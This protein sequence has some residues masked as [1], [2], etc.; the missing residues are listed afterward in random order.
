M[1]E[2]RTITSFGLASV[3]RLS[4]PAIFGG[5]FFA[6]GI[7]LILSLFGLAI[8][9]A[10]AGPEGATR[11]V[12]TWSGIWSLVTVFFGF[13][14]GGWLAARA[15]SV[16][17]MEGRLHGL[18]TWGLGATA[19]FYFAVNS[20][21]RIAAIVANMTGNLGQTSVAPTTVEHITVAAA[22]WALIA[23]I[24]G[25]IGAIVGGH[26]GAYPQQPAVASEVRRAA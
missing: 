24:C 9:A 21:T 16:T 25:L 19:L 4:W 7:M 14:A 5:T 12:Q 26:A 15:S 1:K 17:K 18:V 8:G 6:F 22:T 3:R 10:A 20:T 23:T 11:G 2:E 13:L